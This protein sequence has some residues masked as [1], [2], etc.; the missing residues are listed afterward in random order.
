MID[1]HRRDLLRRHVHERADDPLI[2]GEPSAIE[3]ER[4]HDP[5]VADPNAALRVEEDVL[6]LHVAVHET[7]RVHRSEPFR[8]LARDPQGLAEGE[9]AL[10]IDPRAEN[11]TSSFGRS[12]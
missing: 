4:E 10:R 3:L 7:R 1:V 2:A 5:E 6:R 12:M 8:H 11:K 9:R